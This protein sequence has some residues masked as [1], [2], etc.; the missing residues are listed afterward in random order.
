M[1][2][3]SRPTMD[4]RAINTDYKSY[5]QTYLANGILDY[6]MREKKLEDAL[7]KATELA[8]VLGA[9]FISTWKPWQAKCLRL[10]SA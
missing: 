3:S 2:T 5:A 6:Y 7:K 8:V 9:G 4:A 10:V 1:I